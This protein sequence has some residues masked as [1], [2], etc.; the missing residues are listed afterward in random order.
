MA[1]DTAGGDREIKELLL[2]HPGDMGSA[3]G[4]IWRAA[5]LRVHWLPEGR[6]A[7]CHRR[8]EAAGLIPS[9]LAQARERCDLIVS[10]CPP[11]A[12]RA[13][14]GQVLAGGF[15]GL[16]LDA[17]AISP[18]ASAE[19]GEIAGRAGAGYVDGGIIGPPP[20][21]PNSARLY[22]SGAHA[23]PLAAHLGGGG[24]SVRALDGPPTKASALKMSFAAWNKGLL[25]L[26]ADVHAL[27]DSH[28]VLMPLRDEWA[29][30]DPEVA[31]REARMLAATRKA[32]RWHGEMNEIADTF[33][34][35]G[36]PDGFH[37]GAAEV[38]R[39]LEAFKDAAASP[40]LAELNRAIR[41]G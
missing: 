25:A 16:Y 6:S 9:T 34:A 7:A 13:V 14:A 28:D 38:Y 3:L 11:H 10:V 5:G 40:T 39:R 33:A 22:L 37:R 15:G 24:L 30:L 36:L 31:G 19:V 2:L 23:R 26:L 21:G 27:A 4:T 29:L 12:A 41:D 1:K 17:N 18:A 32:W 35:A 20:R 8:A